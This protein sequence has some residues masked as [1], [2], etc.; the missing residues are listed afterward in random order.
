MNEFFGG[1]PNRPTHPDMDRLSAALLWLDG[2]SKEGGRSPDEILDGRVDTG[3]L[4]YM[5]VQRGRM[6][7]KA[8]GVPFEPLAA[9]WFDGFAAALRF[10]EEGG[11]R[12]T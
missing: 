11:H 3:S 6:L 2:E 12:G 5:A 7:Q 10:I 9:V 4:T 1:D 8:T